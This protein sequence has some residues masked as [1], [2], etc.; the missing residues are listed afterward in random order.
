[1]SQAYG[2]GKTAGYDRDGTSVRLATANDDLAIASLRRAWTEERGGLGAIDDPDFEPAFLAWADDERG[3]RI[4]WLAELD[5]QVV[6]MLNMVLFTRMPRP[7]PEAGPAPLGQWGYIANNFV[8]AEHRNLG[9]GS[10]LLEVAVA[11]A[12]EHDFA[13]IVLTPSEQSI[14]YYS[15]AGFVP[16]T[17]LLVRPG[18][19]DTLPG[20]PPR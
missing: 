9:I 8:L 7:V 10:Q 4:N 13:R 6:G 16:A 11:Y 2:G 18:R 3:R 1:M 12:D 19:G 20:A 5:G 17:A 15:R 14:P